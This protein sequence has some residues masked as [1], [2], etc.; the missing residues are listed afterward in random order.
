MSSNITST[1]YARSAWT[2]QKSEH[3]ESSEDSQRPIKKSKT[4]VSKFS[5]PKEL[6]GSVFEFDDS[7][8]RLARVSKLWNEAVNSCYSFFYSSYWNSPNLRPFVNAIPNNIPTEDY[9][10]PETNPHRR[11]VIATFQRITH[12]VKELNNGIHASSL[13]KRKNETLITLC[14][15]MPMIGQLLFPKEQDLGSLPI[16]I[17][18]SFVEE[19]RDVLKAE[20]ELTFVALS[21]DEIPEE[22]GDLFPRLTTLNLCDTEYLK[23]LTRIETL[24]DLT[25]LDLSDGESI[26]NLAPLA[27]LENLKTL[28]LEFCTEVKDIS[29]LMGLK[30][31]T[32]VKFAS[33]TTR[34]LPP[35]AQIEELG[36]R[37]GADIT[38]SMNFYREDN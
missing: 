11:E 30:K 10:V 26:E 34:D 38:I 5:L 27:K 17:F 25:S 37:T 6:L 1:H 21:L 8:P 13:E 9:Q 23:D 35:L 16:Q 19:H 4:E 33:E 28:N 24:K 22:L 36:R 18:Q 12:S 32:N 14:E 31:L 7:P 29:P 20:T 2:K 15:S 3:E